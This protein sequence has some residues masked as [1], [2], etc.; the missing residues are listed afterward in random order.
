MRKKEL[1]TMPCLLAVAFLC[2]CG[3]GS[4]ATSDPPPDPPPPLGQAYAALHTFRGGSGGKSPTEGLIR[5]AVGNLY[6]TT[7]S[8]GDLACP[9]GFGG[10]C[11]TAFKVDTSGVLTTLHDFAGGAK[12]GAT[13]QEG[14]I[15]DASGNLYGTTYGGGTHRF[16]TVF[17][18]DATGNESVLH[19][20]AGGAGGMFPN[21]RLLRDAVGNLYGTT[22][23]GGD[24][25]CPD[26]FDG[27]GC[28]TVFKLNPNAAFTTLRAFAGGTTGGAFPN[29][30]LILDADGNLYGST[31]AGGNRPCPINVN[32]WGC[33]TVFKLDAKGTESVLHH[34][35]GE[36]PEGTAPQGT[37]IA[38]G[39]GNLYGTTAFGGYLGCG[40]LSSTEGCGTV[41]KL[42]A[43][44]TLTTLFVFGHRTD[45]KDPLPGLIRDSVGNLYG[46]TVR[47][48]AHGFGA[49]FRLN[50]GGGA[51]SLYSFT[52]SA[53]GIRPNL[54]VL[55]SVGNFYGAAYA[56]GDPSCD[57]ANE[58][59]GVV[60]KIGP[61]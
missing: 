36:E 32:G 15:G 16:G 5:D 25:A 30:G 24:L 55:D 35:T 7:T 39:A 11:G 59:C 18:L 42:N 28:G 38:D 2:G 14:L 19:H 50:P 54:D 53:Q 48:G 6:G 40:A 31:T 37:L 47:G 57:P 51:T 10:G 61:P 56:G 49:M 17:K 23:S 22:A 43:G 8:G 27:N 33:G 20:F 34:F 9:D 58:G 60:F 12:D 1:A 44:G 41:F 3:G 21:G 13:P 52:G 46:T 45:L 29:A 4:S 26:S